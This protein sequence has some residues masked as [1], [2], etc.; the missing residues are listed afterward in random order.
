LRALRGA[1]ENHAAAVKKGAAENVDGRLPAA[2]VARLQSEIARL[3][4]ELAKIQGDSPLIQVCVDSQAVAEVVSGWTG[5]P[6]GKVMKDEIQTVLTLQDRLQERVIGQSH[7]LDAISQR[8]RTSRAKL[9]D[10]RRPIGV[11]MLVGPS[12][13]GK[14]E[15]ALA[16]ADALFG[17]ERNLVVI[18]MSEYQESHTVS[19]LKGSPPGYVG[20]GEGGVLTEAVRRKPYSVVLLDEIEK[21]HTDVMEL[22]YQVFDKGM[23]EDGEG[24]EI[25]FKNTLILMTSNAGTDTVA[26]LCADFDT[27]PEPAALAEALRPDLLK[28]FKPAFLGRAIIVPYYPIADEIMKKI[29]ELQLGRIKQRLFENHRAQFTYDPL[30]V[31]EVAKRCTEV[32]SGARNVDHILTRTLLPEIS[33]EFLAKMAGGEAIKTVHVS[34]APSGGFQYDIA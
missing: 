27:R 13:V 29:I 18:N 19:G 25:D 24:R 14:T 17:G 1:I 20:Y 7:A 16:L 15:T 2:E 33:R 10:P 31:E 4:D 21:A 28:I 8:I 23:L 9:E 22:F 30:L 12:G 34:I 3:N 6:V 26:K 32:E 5:I 11:F